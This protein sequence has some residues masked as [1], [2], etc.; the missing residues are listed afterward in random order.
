MGDDLTIVIYAALLAFAISAIICP[1]I[2]PFFRRL[3]LG[4]SIRE[5]GPQSHL[6]K[7]GTPFMGGIAIIVAFTAVSVFFITDGPEVLPVILCTVGYCF[8]GFCDDFIKRIMKRNLGLRAWQKM[9]MQIFVAGGFV[10]LLF[11]QGVETTV[12][13]PFIGTQL[14]LGILYIPFIF[15]VVIGTA[16]GVNLTD[17]LDGLASGV[18]VLV[19]LFFVFVSL[20]L[21]S[22]LTPVIAAAAGALLGFLLFNAH[23]ARIFMGDMG[24]LAL[25]GF[26]ASTAVLLG[27]ELLIPIVGL[28]YM[29]EVFSVMLQVGYYKLTKK[30]TAPGSG[31]F[32]GKRLFKMA[33]IHHHYEQKGW[34]ETKVVA[35]F[36]IITAIMCLVGFLAIS[37]LLA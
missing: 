24:S 11:W 12:F 18:T 17:G 34:P 2:I 22:A 20:V 21:G 10:A 31:K 16:N 5:D 32:Q 19:A 29:V 30:E 36:H 26:V 23:P 8:I 7:A 25:G 28:I 14:N 35:V 3:K 6:S 27:M 1:I 13:V 33:P 37:P 15:F 9:A 4:Q